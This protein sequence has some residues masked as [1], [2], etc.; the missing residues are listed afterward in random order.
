MKTDPAL[1][2]TYDA[3]GYPANPYDSRGKSLRTQTS[4]S[5]LALLVNQPR[6][7]NKGKQHQ[8]E[9]STG[10]PPEWSLLWIVFRSILGIFADV[11]CPP[12]PSP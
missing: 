1:W 6:M 5:P 10:P 12:S 9:E 2:H 8:T 4:E 7:T 3:E 11:D